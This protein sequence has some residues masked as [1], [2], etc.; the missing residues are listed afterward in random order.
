MEALD[1]IRAKPLVKL[2]RHRQWLASTQYSPQSVRRLLDRNARGD[3]RV[4][5]VALPKE[6]AEVLRA[7][8][9]NAN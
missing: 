2:K 6:R 4:E 9:N 5:I 7:L 3:D 8:L 1:I